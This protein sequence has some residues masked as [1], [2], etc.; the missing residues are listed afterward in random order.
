MC[1]CHEHNEHKKN[2]YETAMGTSLVFL[3]GIGFGAWF[4][5]PIAVICGILLALVW[6][7]YFVSYK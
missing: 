2:A 4:F 5:W 6:L 3:A 1:K 7:V